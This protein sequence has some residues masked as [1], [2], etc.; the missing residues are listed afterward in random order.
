M[1][2]EKLNLGFITSHNMTLYLKK[3][4]FIVVFSVILTLAASLRLINLAQV[5]AAPYWE[6]V[7]LGYDAW[8]ILKTGKDHQGN[9]WPVVAFESFGDWK[10]SLYF[11]AITPFILLFDLSVTAV[12]LPAAL[13]GVIMVGLVGW[14]AYLLYPELLSSK[15]NNRK[16][17][18]LLAAFF[19]SISPWAIQFSRG[20]WE[21]QLGTCLFLLGIVLWLKFV[22]AAKLRW[23]SIISI[24]FFVASMYTYHAFR[25]ISPVMGVLLASYWFLVQTRSEKIKV[26]WQHNLRLVSIQAGLALILVLPLL[27]NLTNAQ[28]SQR[29]A[30]TSIF[31][32]V[33]VISQSNQLREISGN[34]FFSYF[35]YHRYVLFTKV[36]VS[37]FLSHFNLSYLFVSG[38]SN[39][40]HSVQYFGL[41]YPGDFL[42]LLLGIYQAIKK[43]SRG[44]FL[45]VGWLVIAYLPASIS[46]AAPH[47]L[48]TLAA[49]PIWMLL[50]AAGATLFWQE[51]K[52]LLVRFGLIILTLAIVGQF[53]AYQRFYW[54]VYPQLYAHEWQYG[55]Q[56]MVEAVV[57][58]QQQHTEQKVFL[59]R[60]LGRPS[61]YYW[62][63]SKTD[64]V[65]V[66]QAAE[67]VKKDQGEFL[68]FEQF[69]FISS[70][71]EVTSSGLI[72]STP[73]EFQKF[74]S[75]YPET[76]NREFTVN[77]QD[78]RPLWIGYS[79][80]QK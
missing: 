65:R 28:V 76:T 67:T 44:W 60:E 10:P 38:D 64:P 42:L 71:N 22:T 15:E 1:Q 24:F 74:T 58:Y 69:Q 2:Q 48:R 20:G 57:E 78:L 5:P 8:S 33:S 62:F 32:Q 23:L 25:L 4:W 54:L 17:F 13:S 6:E 80:V 50:I 16:V 70:V 34:D 45:L 39:P 79:Y 31:S 37:Q 29:F 3:H 59:T 68:E 52:N 27:I 26:F 19:T 55:Y 77:S 7:A 18:T 43:R 53:I 41:F 35:Y 61:M 73:E 36:V 63:F 21:V 47:A 75:L 11:Y 12:R 56:Q 49:L 40:R 14:L 72:V 51:R 30:E 66:Q 9:V 46:T